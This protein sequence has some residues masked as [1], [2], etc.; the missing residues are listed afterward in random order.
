MTLNIL[1]RVQLCFQAV[2]SRRERRLLPCLHRR[3]VSMASLIEH[4]RER[5]SKN[6]NQCVADQCATAQCVAGPSQ[7]IEEIGRIASAF[8]Q[9]CRSFLGT[10]RL[11]M[12]FGPEVRKRKAGAQVRAVRSASATRRAAKISILGI[13]LVFA[14]G[15]VVA[16]AAFS[17]F[18]GV[19]QLSS[20]TRENL[21][22]WH[23]IAR[24]TDSILAATSNRPMPPATTATMQAELT[25]L[26][27]SELQMT[28]EIKKLAKQS[29]FLRNTLFTTEAEERV[30][31]SA[32][33]DPEVQANIKHLAASPF[34][35]APS[36]FTSWGPMA[37]LN[38]G[39]DGVFKALF[40]RDDLLFSIKSRIIG[41]MWTLFTEIAA[42][43]LF[44]IWL[45]WSYLLAPSLDRLQTAVADSAEH[46]E[47]V[48]QARRELLEREKFLRVLFDNTPG[49]IASID[50]EFRYKSANRTYLDAVGLAHPEQIYGRTIQD[51]LGPTTWQRIQEPLGAALGGTAIKFETQRHARYLQATY[52]PLFDNAGELDGVVAL[53]MDVH[54][55]RV[56]RDALRS[57]EANLRATLNSIEEAVIAADG[58]G[59]ITHMNPAAEA[60]TG[61]KL[62]EVILK[63]FD[64]VV[65]LRTKGSRERIKA[66]ALH[67]SRP[68]AGFGPGTL[69]TSR[70]G[71]DY[72]VLLT[73]SPI[74]DDAKSP[75]GTVIV[76]R[77]ITEENLLRQQISQQ[78]RLKALG[79][80]AGGIAHD[81]NNLLASMRGGAELLQLDERQRLSEK[82]AGIVKALITTCDRAA[83][84]TDRLTR[85]ARH[86]GKDFS[87]VSAR[88]VVEEVIEI[89]GRTIDNKIGIDV[90][91]EAENDLIMGDLSA[92]ESALL[93]LCIN[94]VQ[95]MPN[96]GTLTI[97]TRNVELSANDLR[98]TKFGLTAGLYV[99]LGVIDTGVGIP[100][101]YIDKIFDPFFT[102]KAASAGS[103]I[104]L[105][106]AFG[107]I[108]DHSGALEAMS[109]L[110]KGTKLTM[111]LPCSQRQSVAAA[112]ELATAD[113]AASF[114]GAVMVV[115]NEPVLR[116]ILESLLEIM[117][118]QVIA[119]KDGL[120]A[121]EIY[122]DR[123]SQID[124]VLLDLNMPRIDGRQT[125]A[126]L[127]R[128]N[129]QC[130]IVMMTGFTDPMLF[131]N[132][133]FKGVTVL[134]K[135]I[136]KGD[137][138]AALA[139]AAASP[140]SL[141][142]V[143]AA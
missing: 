138:S 30:I 68:E 40:E 26:L 74:I 115:E 85:F 20:L 109:E 127:R 15:L 113:A 27:E 110:H 48:N 70:H 33:V 57:S 94:S 86:T 129:P 103:G 96:G 28:A 120:E 114:C 78:D 12:A 97:H 49:M 56:A 91:F 63:E 55:Q 47:A 65:E 67:T 76:M 102:T 139:K 117:G 132:E 105:A 16:S 61:A 80:L 81:F 90:T 112:A 140:G 119:A 79:Q 141:A 121:V 73:V 53:I 123:G 39:S 99:E 35:L 24:A 58:S 125:F 50:K 37:G 69:L 52:V 64:D 66:L 23:D 21:R 83:D 54:E 111:L 118:N 11:G 17:V 25:A 36:E 6:S 29:R 72:E 5:R 137:L 3:G 92:L 101:K 2:R 31:A 108:A 116:E 130:R 42:V 9:R 1:R 13:S 19:Q 8:F 14:V 107:A 77:D 136:S 82:G 88:Q 59:R 142:R 87:I 10:A 95:A 124:V 62:T 46:A 133:L 43:V 126:E 75:R 44:A 104:G 41:A 22:K 38:Q 60:M 134:R 32:S 34:P 71:I 4:H 7:R 45:F 122:K 135:P 106:T 51:V 18:S 89:V 93:N 143:P 98:L 131:D 128:M 84:L 100:E